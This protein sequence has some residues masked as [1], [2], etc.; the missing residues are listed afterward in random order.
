HVR[1]SRPECDDEAHARG[2]EG[3]PGPFYSRTPYQPGRR[4]SRSPAGGWLT[5]PG[6]EDWL[7]AP[8]RARMCLYESLK[9]GTLGLE[10][11]ALMNDALAVAADNE[12]LAHELARK[13]H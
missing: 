4:E 10:D 12:V 3:Q 11:I 2:G 7:L 6:G 13:N 5:L 9:D 8:V 1:R